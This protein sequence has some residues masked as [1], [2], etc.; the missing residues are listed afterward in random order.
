[1]IVH[2]VF[3]TPRGW[4]GLAASDAGLVSVVM[5]K[6]DPSL[7]L[8]EIAETFSTCYSEDHDVLRLARQEILEYLEGS[9][10][11]FTV[12]LDL[13]SA[14]SFRRKVWEATISIPRGECR[15]Y[16]WLAMDV[17]SPRASRA[18]GGAMGANPLP[19]IIPCHR[20]ISSSGALGGYSGGLDT[21][22]WLLELE[23]WRGSK[24]LAEII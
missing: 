18:I 14:T 5:P 19:I 4:M 24:K 15:S 16:L 7:A 21:K 9:N 11:S 17:G 12:P 8:E 22:R 20:V 13:S 10:K 23:G 1:M 3:I 6:N 2:D